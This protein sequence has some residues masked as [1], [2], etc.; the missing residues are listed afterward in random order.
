MSKTPEIRFLL[1]PQFSN[2][3]ALTIKW[4][5]MQK[6]LPLTI[7][8]SFC[9]V[10]T[11]NAF[12]QVV[13][14]EYSCSNRD[15]IADQNGNYEDY[16]ELYNSSGS[17]VDLTGYYLSDDYSALTKWAFPSGIS[18]P[19]NG[20][21]KVWA[22]SKDEVVGTNIHTNFKLTQT[23]NEVI[24]F[25]NPSGQIIDSVS[26]KLTQKNHARGRTTNGGATWGVFTNPTPGTS[27]GA[28]FTEYAA[29]PVMDIPEGFYAAAQTVTVTDLDPNVTIHYTTDGSEPTASSTVYSAP[30]SISATTVLRVRGFSSVAGMLPSFSET[31]TYFINVYHDP[32]YYVISLA[33]DDFD[34]LFTG[35]GTWNIDAY[36]EFFDRNHVLQAEGEGKV[37]P[38]GNDSWAFPQKG[39][40]FEMEDDYGYAHT[41]PYKI[42]DDK[43]R[44]NFDHIILKAGASDNYPFS[45]G[46]G[47][48]HMRDA[49]AH[50]LAVR[51]H[52]DID[53]R[54]YEPA[55]L[56]ING[57]YWGIYDLREKVDEPDYTD[58]YYNQKENDIDFCKFWGG[59]V[60]PYGSDTAWNNLYY[61][62]QANPMTVPANYQH[63]KDRL[64]FTSM[65][66]YM[67]LNTYLVDCD[68]INWN[69]MWWRGR[70]PDGDKT[71]WTYAFWDED[72]ILG[73]GE[74]YSGWP[75]TGFN[76]DPCDLNPVFNNAGPDMGHL[77]MLD[78]LLLNN[79]FKNLYINR[80]ADLMN[81]TLNCDTMTGLLNE[82][83]NILT[84]EMPGQTARWG[85][86]VAGWQAN[87]DYV[88][89][90]ISQ[91]CAY[92]DSAIIDCYT[93]TGPYDVT[94]LVDPPLSGDVQIST[95]HPSVY[96]WTGTYF[97]NVDLN[98]AAT[99]ATNM[100][101][102]YWEV[103]NNVINPNQYA[104]SITMNLQA[105]DTVIA[106]FENLLPS[107]SLNVDVEP[108]GSGNV[109][110]QSYTPSIYPYSVAY[111]SGQT[112]N[113]SAT[114]ETGYTFNYWTLN[115][116]FV[117][118]NSTDPNVYFTI[119]T[120][121]DIVAHFTELTGIDETN[122]TSLE[123]YP[124]LTTD[125]F[126]LAFDLKE[127][128]DLKVQLYSLS[129]QLVKDLVK[130]DGSLQQPGNHE[131]NVSMKME[132]LSPGV[133]FLK[134][135]YPGFSKTFKLVL[136]PK[137]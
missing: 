89:N 115:N 43:D 39:I 56:Y 84:P 101:F 80:Y 28:S 67:V 10:A 48:C 12:S 49:Y 57:E 36:I 73:L 131:M 125:Q 65:I 71:K 5:F 22:S 17:T 102:S 34:D 108:T 79:D 55:I 88:Q 75:T 45:W 72:N 29:A 135:T 40:D 46:T 129:G 51:H 104:D 99:P 119:A 77:D 37:D 136:M 70:N 62:M 3:R 100:V 61:Y 23:K 6:F 93:V 124:T 116:H 31:N 112:I 91:R 127:F 85:G 69:T 134:F 105:G 32:Q 128:V 76:A 98:F 50:T 41:I 44:L 27:N 121:D 92:I 126:H 42:F 24:A 53:V 68:W 103:N 117:N 94:V 11:F 58:H 4:F 30:I 97:G 2:F 133:Y 130:E 1:S 47:G 106:H 96:P 74:N 118:P 19:A 120:G 132:D 18:I 114:P 54:T 13:I 109:S 25:S 86:S 111:T 122:V 26:L 63:V 66:D 9:L 35:W 38:H 95:L 33:S 137:P 60:V 123:V 21:L 7:A 113:L 90:F 15:I 107:F 87:I 82:F 52:L 110:I 64:N 20:F 83:V 59:L 14:N 16:I 78:W 8:I 81:T